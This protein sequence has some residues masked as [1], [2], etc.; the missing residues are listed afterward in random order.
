MIN[1]LGLKGIG[2]FFTPK[3]IVLPLSDVM[4][5]PQEIQM[6]RLFT[7]SHSSQNN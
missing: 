7:E 3:L 6:G 1:E 2:L 4:K 5:N